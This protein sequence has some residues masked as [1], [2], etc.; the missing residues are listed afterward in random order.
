MKYKYFSELEL[1]CKCCGEMGMDLEFILDLED[2][3]HEART[4]FIITSGYRCIKHNAAVGGSETS[5]H[6]KGLAVDI[7]A[8]T[9]RERMII[10]GSLFHNGFNRIGIA[11]TFIH[12]DK[13]PDKAPGVMW[14]Y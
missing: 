7:K 5:S 11:K 12:T 1:K 10:V 2:A 9:S 8:I 14:L 6:L 3:R 13:D 4:P